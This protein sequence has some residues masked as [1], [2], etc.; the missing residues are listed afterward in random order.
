[1]LRCREGWGS[2]GDGTLLFQSH[3]GV[4]ISILH[5]EEQLSLRHACYCLS[6]L[7]LAVGSREERW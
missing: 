5:W 6:F 3:G 2:L 1:M 4:Q 7:E